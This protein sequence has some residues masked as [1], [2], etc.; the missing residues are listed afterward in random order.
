MFK[1]QALKLNTEH[2]KGVQCLCLTNTFQ[3]VLLSFMTPHTAQTV[4][5]GE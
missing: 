3:R 1:G 4:R 5:Y 2:W